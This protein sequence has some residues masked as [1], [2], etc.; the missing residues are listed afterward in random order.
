M[1]SLDTIQVD[2]T[3]LY[4]RINDVNI[5]VLDLDEEVNSIKS[6]ISSRM[7]NDFDFSKSLNISGVKDNLN[8]YHDTQFKFN[9]VNCSNVVSNFNSFTNVSG[10]VYGDGLCFDNCF[11]NNDGL[12]DFV[13]SPESLRNCFNDNANLGANIEAYDLDHCLNNGYFNSLILDVRNLRTCLNNVSIGTGDN[14]FI[15]ADLLSSVLNSFNPVN[16]VKIHVDAMNNDRMLN[17]CNIKRLNGYFNGDVASYCFNTLTFDSVGSGITKMR[18]VFLNYQDLRSC[19]VS[20]TINGDCAIYG[21]ALRMN[22]CFKSGVINQDSSR[23]S[24]AYSN[25]VNANYADGCFYSL[26]L[27]NSIYFNNSFNGCSSLYMAISYN[28]YPLSVNLNVQNCYYCFRSHTDALLNVRLNALSMYYCFNYITHTHT[29]SAI[30]VGGYVG[31]LSSWFNYDNNIQR[32]S[33]SLNGNVAIGL[34]YNSNTSQTSVWYKILVVNMDYNH[35]SNCFV[36]L[37]Y[38]TSK[39]TAYVDAKVNSAYSCFRDVYNSSGVCRLDAQIASSCFMNITCDSVNCIG[40]DYTGCLLNSVYISSLNLNVNVM[41]GCVQNTVSV[42]YLRGNCEF[43]SNCFKNGTISFLNVIANSAANLV[44]T[45]TGNEYYLNCPD[46]YN[47]FHKCSMLRAELN[48]NSSM[49]S[50]VNSCSI[51]Y[52]DINGDK[53]LYVSNCLDN[54]L[55]TTFAVHCPLAIRESAF[56]SNYIVS[57]LVLD[58]P[59]EFRGTQQWQNNSYGTGLYLEIPN[60]FWIGSDTSRSSVGIK[61]NNNVLEFVWPSGGIVSDMEKYCSNYTSLISA[62][63]TNTNKRLVLRHIVDMA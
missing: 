12:C 23:T 50:C 46:L 33:L 54:N 21:N 58:Y 28:N 30:S 16:N 59:L 8:G 3:P 49:A 22:E 14:Y 2:L 38:S 42:R 1:I 40:N 56:N 6:D 9:C 61:I 19:F 29:Y 55:F 7:F 44:H 26:T 39:M 4:T 25:Y 15:K 36:G 57:S 43:I 10:S 45:L 63:Y 11:N 31:T 52:F 60:M 34:L 24:L 20:N 37:R 41:Y 62:V 51:A 53:T 48:V 13:L 17:N 35:I 47:A 18:E 32:L 27:N 5:R